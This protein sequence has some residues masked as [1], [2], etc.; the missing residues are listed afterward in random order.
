VRI[1]VAEVALQQAPH[2]DGVL[3]HHRLIQAKLLAIRLDLLVARVR[4][5]RRGHRIRRHQ[6]RQKEGQQRDAEYDE[7]ETAQAADDEGGHGQL[8]IVRLSIANC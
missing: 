2:V 7:D 1:D 6:L 8:E 5:Q 4:P 3:R